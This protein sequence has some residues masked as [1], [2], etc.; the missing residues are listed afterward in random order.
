MLQNLVVFVSEDFASMVDGMFGRTSGATVSGPS[1]H[2]CVG[3][4]QDMCTRKP[5]LYVHLSLDGIY[6]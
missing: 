4:Q 3:F 5:G 1:C 2:V 6:S